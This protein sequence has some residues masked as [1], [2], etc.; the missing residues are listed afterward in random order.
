MSAAEVGTL[1]DSRQIQYEVWATLRHGGGRPC[2][3]RV[4]PQ[5]RAKALSPPERYR[6]CWEFEN[7]YRKLEQPMLSTA[8]TL[9]NQQPQGIEQKI[10]GALIAYN[11][12][13]LEMAKA[14]S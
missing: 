9:R 7:S 6:W 3:M 12:A 4:S 5:A 10:L 1:P 14:A 11:L 2:G 13:H 8:L